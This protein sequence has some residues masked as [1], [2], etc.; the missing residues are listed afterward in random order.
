MFCRG[1]KL[2][3]TLKEFLKKDENRNNL[4]FYKEYA[5]VELEMGRFNN[6]VSILETAIQSQGACP[7]AITN[8]SERAALFSVYRTFIETL[9]DT[10][11]YDESHNQWILKVFGQMIPGESADQDTLVEAYLYKYVRDFLQTAPNENGKDFFFLSNLECDAIVCYAYLLYIKNNDIQT[12]MEI[13]KSCIDH[14][15]DYPYMQVLIQ[16]Y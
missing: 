12:V 2:R 4:Y 11:T 6:C 16:L 7:S 5:L 14:S 10:R 1:K 9:L 15:K 8:E 3:A 13:L